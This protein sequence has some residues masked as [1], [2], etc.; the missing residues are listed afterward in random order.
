MHLLELL[1]RLGFGLDVLAVH[2]KFE[3][4]GVVLHSSLEPL[5]QFKHEIVVCTEL[6][7]LF[8]KPLVLCHCRRVYLYL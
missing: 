1:L 2:S 8:L 3:S 5:L 6:T 4:L 7:I